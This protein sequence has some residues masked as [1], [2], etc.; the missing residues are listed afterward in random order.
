M[1]RFPH[2]KIR[3]F[4]ALLIIIP[5]AASVYAQPEQKEN[6]TLTPLKDFAAKAPTM[7]YNDVMAAIKELS[8]KIPDDRLPIV[9]GFG[10][11]DDAKDYRFGFVYL[12]VDRNRFDSAARLIVKSVAGTEQDR[13]YIMWKWWEGN[14]GERKD[15]IELS[16]RIGGALLHNLI[17]AM[18]RR[19]WLSPKY[20]AK[21][22]PKQR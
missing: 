3:C 20:S 9:E 10:L 22:K 7:K 6:E 18:K 12:L 8:K 15:Y 16:H 19:S 11:T 1:N 14:F 2:L 4:I 17:T 13:E 5:S 21:A